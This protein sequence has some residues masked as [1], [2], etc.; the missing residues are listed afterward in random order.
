MV[1]GDSDVMIT[2]ELMSSFL[3]TVLSIPSFQ[4]LQLLVTL[5]SKDKLSH[6]H[7][8]TFATS[9]SVLSALTFVVLL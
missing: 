6:K 9:T 3:S 1:D 8:T 4:A 5:N 2:D 7:S